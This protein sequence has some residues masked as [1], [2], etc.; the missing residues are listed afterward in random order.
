[1]FYFHKAP[2]IIQHLFSSYLWRRKTANKTI[3]L[4]FDD[5]PTPI[6]TNWVLQ[7]LSDF[8]AKATF[9]CLG[10]NIVQH[11]EIAKEIIKGS[12]YIA[13]HGFS[14]YN[15]FW[16]N[17][18]KYVS[19]VEKTQALINA[20]KKPENIK[21]P[22]LFRPPYG[23][24]GVFQANELNKKAYRIVMWEILSGDFDV[25]LDTSK[26]IK[27]ILKHAKKGSIIVFHDS[28]KAFSNLKKILPILLQKWE[29]EG[30]EFKTL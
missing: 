2:K 5:G 24:I 20:L 9:F 26:A 22:K 17:N 21:Q 14:H 12:H 16:T 19:D 8:N 1:M 10:K 6:V 18:T 30:Y 3:Y 15:G 25:K 7:T 4:T 11:Q 27:Q 29:E 23:K 13:N 28:E